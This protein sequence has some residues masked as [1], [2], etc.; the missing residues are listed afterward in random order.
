MPATDFSG[1]G[2]DG[3][4]WR[5]GRVFWFDSEKGFGYIKPD[6][7]TDQVFVEYRCIETDGY[8]TLHAG[9]PVLFVSTARPRGHEAVTVRPEAGAGLPDTAPGGGQSRR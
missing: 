5:R 4:D 8:R 9:Q 2:I 1:P 7:G 3:S 6:D